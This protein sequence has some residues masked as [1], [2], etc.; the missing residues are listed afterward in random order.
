[1]KKIS[2]SCY[3]FK[4]TIIEIEKEEKMGIGLP[5]S[6]IYL[7]A[8]ELYKELVVINIPFLF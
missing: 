4:R 3:G 6:P 7:D 1:M 2:E 5:C 8:I